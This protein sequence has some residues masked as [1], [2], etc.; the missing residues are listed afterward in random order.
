MGGTKDSMAKIYA[1]QI[2]K[3]KMTFEQVPKIMQPKVA[4]VLRDMDL[5]DLIPEGYEG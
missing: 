3:G 4:E 5:E 1:M 2:I